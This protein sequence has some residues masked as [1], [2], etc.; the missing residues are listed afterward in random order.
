[1]PLMPSL[2]L[3]LPNRTSTGAM[4]GTGALNMFVRVRDGWGGAGGD[5]EVKSHN[6][7]VVTSTGAF[8]IGGQRQGT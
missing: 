8:E 2:E 5:G 6:T 3:S 1:M 4:M 7:G